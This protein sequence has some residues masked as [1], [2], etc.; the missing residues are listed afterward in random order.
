MSENGANNALLPANSERRVKV[1]NLS[2]NS[3]SKLCR[4]DSF[5]SFAIAI[6]EIQ[7]EHGG[8][9]INSAGNYVADPMPGWRR[10]DQ[11]GH[12]RLTSPADSLRALTVGSLAHLGHPNACA[13]ADE[14]SP[15]TRKGPGAAYVPKPEISHYGGNTYPDQQYRQ[16]G[17]ISTDAA[18]NLS[19]TVGTSFAAPLAAVTAAKLWNSLDGN[20]P[21]HLVKA[22]MIHSAVLNSETITSEDLPYTGFGKPPSVED[23]L[24][25]NPSE[26]TLIFEL[27]LPYSHRNFHKPDFPVPPCL[28]REDGK[29]FG[30]IIMTLVYD[31][32]VDP[33]D[34]AAYSQVNI[35]PSVGVCWV[36]GDDEDYSGKLVPYPKDY[37]D[38]FEKNQIQHGFK[39]SPVKVYRANF[40]RVTPRDMWRIT[41]DM[42]TRKPEYKPDSQ[43]VA[44]IVTIRDPAGEQP[45][46]DEVIA[47][48]NRSGWIT[49]NLPIKAR[50]RVRA[51]S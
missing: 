13:Q 10:P 31:P 21:R 5:S 14:P 38:L 16:L 50:A 35:N 2:V 3:V 44:L 40:S 17:I 20:P 49:Q 18:G 24:Q 7:D 27:D 28:H 32:P 6:D 48:M 19:E 46:Y 34:G 8:I 36:D 9:I 51:A 41:M 43:P 11:G 1:W 15:F 29:V 12:D 37:R 33:Y 39:W 23:M 45:V 25:C 47:M 26:A 4:D 22:M 42:S 30:E